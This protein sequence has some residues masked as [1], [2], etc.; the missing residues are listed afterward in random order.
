MNKEPMS[1]NKLDFRRCF[2]NTLNTKFDEDIIKQYYSSNPHFVKCVDKLNLLQNKESINEDLIQCLYSLVDIFT[3]HEDIELIGSEECTSNTSDDFLDDFGY[4]NRTHKSLKL[5]IARLLNAY[6]DKNERE[7]ALSDISSGDTKYY[8]TFY[9]ERSFIW[10]YISEVDK[11]DYHKALDNSNLN[12]AMAQETL[13]Y[14]QEKE[15][16]EKLRNQNKCNFSILSMLSYGVYKLY[17]SVKDYTSAVLKKKYF[18]ALAY[19][20]NLKNKEMKTDIP[21]N[22]VFDYSVYILETL[23]AM[24]TFE[25]I[26]QGKTLLKH[27]HQKI[28]SIIRTHGYMESNSI[29]LYPELKHR[30]LVTVKRPPMMMNSLVCKENLLPYYTYFEALKEYQH[31]ESLLLKNYQSSVD[32]NLKNLINFILEHKCQNI[33]TFYT[34]A[35]ANEF[36]QIEE[37]LNDVIPKKRIF[38]KEIIEKNNNFQFIK[39]VSNL[40]KIGYKIDSDNKKVYNNLKKEIIFQ[41]PVLYL[42]KLVKYWKDEKKY[43]ETHVNK[44]VSFLETLNKAMNLLLSMKTVSI[45]SF[46]DYVN[47]KYANEAKYD[48]NFDFEKAFNEYTESNY[49]ERFDETL[50]NIDRFILEETNNNECIVDEFNPEDLIDDKIH[51][52]NSQIHQYQTLKNNVTAGIKFYTDIEKSLGIS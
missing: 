33:I 17:D 30:I 48:K 47:E 25:D 32:Y 44:M 1:K 6:L 14:S 24:K 50:Q 42:P 2:L 45:M 34:E 43:E 22:V 4:E 5:E 7:L 51:I 40:L 35:V 20:Y 46:V 9:R 10:K 3:K 49:K 39:E 18:I 23:A 37:L 19:H 52:Y 12:L 41:K 13:F 29:S 16:L 26:Q 15:E 21:L 27:Y 28:Q 11:C 36:K 38:I 8:L 31:E